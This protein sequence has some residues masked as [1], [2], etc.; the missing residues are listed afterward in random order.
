[1]SVPKE[2]TDLF[3][4]VSADEAKEPL[5]YLWVYDP[6]EDKIHVE[7]NEGRHRAEHTDHG[8]LGRRVADPE[9]VHGYAYPIGGGF[10][11]TS[12]DHGSV[13]D[14]HI[15]E[16]VRKALKGES[17]R[18]HTGSLIQLRGLR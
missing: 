17:S 8:E 9:R 5:Y 18:S 3:P 12:W 4:K 15:K 10:R 6:R 13:D 7:H 1:M 2:F 11:I 16:A 14:P